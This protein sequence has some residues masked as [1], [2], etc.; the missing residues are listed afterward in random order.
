MNQC[1]EY[2]IKYLISSNFSQC[3]TTSICGHLS[4]PSTAFCWWCNQQLGGWVLHHNSFSLNSEYVARHRHRRRH[5]IWI[6]IRIRIQIRGCV[7]IRVQ[8]W[9]SL[10]LTFLA[11][12]IIQF[13]LKSSVPH[14][15]QYVHMYICMYVCVYARSHRSVSNIQHPPFSI[16]HPPFSILLICINAM[17]VCNAGR[18]TKDPRLQTSDC[19]LH[20][21]HCL[22]IF[23]NKLICSSWHNCG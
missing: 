3:L 2:N 12:N 15:Q 21:A 5:R 7:R 9:R 4:G 8:V 19:K 14:S 17:H 18:R 20:M 13:G 16:L 1:Y 23:I 6:R 10:S 11:S 22:E